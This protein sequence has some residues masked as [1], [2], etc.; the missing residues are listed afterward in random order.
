M[1]L[2]ISLILAIIFFFAVDA[3]PACDGYSHSRYRGYQGYQPGYIPQMLP[4]TGF[5]PGLGGLYNPSTTTITI[6]RK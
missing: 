6:E 2:K 4:P 5:Q 3:A 1:S